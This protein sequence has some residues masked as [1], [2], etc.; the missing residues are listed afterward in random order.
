MKRFELYPRMGPIRVGDGA[1]A[2]L[3]DMDCRWN[4]SR[5]DSLSKTKC[6]K[7]PY[8][9]KEI[10]CRVTETL[11]RGRTVYRDGAICAVPGIEIFI[12]P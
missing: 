10:L 4:Y 6:T 1:E 8:E 7:F 12:K 11:V 9:G 5:K 3:V 2:I